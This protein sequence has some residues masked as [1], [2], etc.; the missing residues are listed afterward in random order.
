MA[1]PHRGQTGHGTYFVTANTFQ[2]R[3]LLQSKRAVNL[4]IETLYHWRAERKLLLHEFVLM[5]NHFHLL[6]TPGDDITLER[7]LG[8]VKGRFS[9]EA[10]LQ[11]GL[12]GEIWQT[13]FY[14]RR[15]R[16]W[17]EFQRFRRYI[18][19]NPV[20][21]GLVT[22]AKDFSFSSASGRFELDDIPQRLKPLAK[23]AAGS[24]G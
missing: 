22:A 6:T 9:H 24:Q 20:R 19:E 12:Q 17:Q 11:L 10:R 5:P 13:S 1:I 3:N 7:V 2:K 21:R 14:D 8:L 16:D 15:I 4:L 18:H 23:E